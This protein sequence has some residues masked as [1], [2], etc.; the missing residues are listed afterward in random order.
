MVAAG[1]TKTSVES[2]TT[3]GQT[4]KAARLAKEASLTDAELATSIAGKYLAALEESRYHELPADVYS[5]GFVKRYAR[6]LNLNLET[7]LKQYRAEQTIVN[8]ANPKHKAEVQRL[9]RPRQL[10]KAHRL[11][12][13][14]ERFVALAAGLATLTVVSYLWFQVKSFAAAPSLDVATAVDNSIVHVV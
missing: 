13:T 11:W 9:T 8:V 7:C 12:I 6:Y 14:P 3:L 4:L 10:L 1:F 5:V 2:V